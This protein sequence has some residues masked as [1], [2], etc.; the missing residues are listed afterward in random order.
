MTDKQ[1]NNSVIRILDA[2]INRAG[3]GLRVVEDY[4][5]MVL[6]DSH[7]ATELKQLRHDL[8]ESVSSIDSTERMAARDSIDDV[9]RTIATESEYRREDAGSVSAPSGGMLQANFARA[10]QAFRTI[11]EFSKTI[12]ISIAK[13]VEQLRYRAYTLEK[14]VL[15]TVVSLQNFTDAKLYSLINSCELR[16]D[17][18][19]GLSSLVKQLVDSNV[20]IIQLRDKSLTDR[21]LVQAGKLISGLTRGSKTRFI[22]NDRA[23]LAVAS[24][25]DGVHLGQDDLKVSDARRLVGAARMIGVSTHSIEQARAAVLAGANYI[26]VGPVF[27]STTKSFDSHVGLALVAQVANEIQLPAFAIGGINLQNVSQIVQAGM[28]RVAVGAA[29][30]GSED[31]KESALSF[32]RLLES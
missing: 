18:G 28:S 5:R 27:E 4:V 7:L 22:M 24:N 20:G 26:G 30:A 13:P 1:S 29:I 11:E 6:G 15:T 17:D 10:Q 19:Q 16:S 21:E 32:K 14:A 31:V 3:E 25:A 8:T 2:S 12:D 9:G 23:D